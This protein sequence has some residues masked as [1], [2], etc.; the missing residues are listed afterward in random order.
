MYLVRSSTPLSSASRTG[1]QLIQRAR[2]C[3]GGQR[4][5][6]RPETVAVATAAPEQ[7]ASDRLATARYLRPAQWPALRVLD[8]RRN[9]VG[10]GLPLELGG[11]FEHGMQIDAV[12]GLET[13]RGHGSMRSLSIRPLSTFAA[14]SA[15]FLVPSAAHLRSWPTALLGVAHRRKSIWTR[16]ALRLPATLRSRPS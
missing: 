8:S 6:S 13:D 3:G 1:A 16:T 15:L 5:A 10:H 12:P 2:A 4:L 14:S 7:S 11:A 9:K